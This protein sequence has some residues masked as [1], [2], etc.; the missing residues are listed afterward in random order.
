MTV[1]SY[2]QSVL[3]R[4]KT[5]LTAEG[6]IATLSDDYS[7]IQLGSTGRIEHKS[8]EVIGYIKASWES[9]FWNEWHV[10]EEDG[11]PAW[12]VEAMGHFSYV[13]AMNF[14]TSFKRGYQFNIGENIY[15]ESNRFIVTDIKQFTCD[16][17]AGELPFHVKQ[18]AQGISID[19]KSHVGLCAYI[20]R[21]RDQTRVFVGQFYDLDELK[22]TN[23]RELDDW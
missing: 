16:Y 1:C 2:C 14:P 8:F 11:E 17:I 18:K 10:V 7:V 4:D 21:I 9:G 20:E 3:H 13:R 23:L 15:L 12:L 22:L 6:K 5:T 19:L